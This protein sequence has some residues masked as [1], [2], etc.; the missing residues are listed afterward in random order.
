MKVRNGLL[1]GA[2]LLF[3]IPAFAQ[4]NSSKLDIA[5]DFSFARW[6]AA[7]NYSD[8]VNLYG[9]GGSITSFFADFFG[10][11]GEFTGYGSQTQI[12]N[13]RNGGGAFVPV[14]LNGNFFTYLFGPVVQ[15]RS[16]VFKPFGEVLLGAAHTNLYANVTTNQALGT[17]PSSDAFAMAVGGGLDLRLNKHISLRLGEADYLLT[18]FNAYNGSAVAPFFSN[19]NQNNFR[20]LSGIVFSF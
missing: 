13:I 15:K 1:L 17:V 2:I 3:G 20:V 18:H 11:K 5:L 16:G 19:Y 9:G 4:N 6:N 14:R 10:I 12:V 8:T 7:G